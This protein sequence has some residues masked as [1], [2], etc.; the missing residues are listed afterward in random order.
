MCYLPFFRCL[1]GLPTGP[2]QLVLP[3]GKSNTFPFTESWALQ[4]LRY[5]P[6]SPRVPKWGQGY[7]EP[8][9]AQEQLLFP[10]LGICSPKNG[11]QQLFVWAL[12]TSENNLF[13]SSLLFSFPPH[14]CWFTSPW[15][16]VIPQ[17]EK[18]RTNDFGGVCARHFAARALTY[19]RSGWA[20]TQSCSTC[21]LWASC[22]LHFSFSIYVPAHNMPSHMDQKL[23]C[24]WAFS[25]SCLSKD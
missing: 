25:I 16:Y 4:C 23:N 22:P 21:L 18:H 10:P 3:L 17:M 6:R 13:G 12:T 14:Q 20:E 1:V 2:V 11:L 5:I 19:D 24:K 15:L 9:W 8:P 7:R